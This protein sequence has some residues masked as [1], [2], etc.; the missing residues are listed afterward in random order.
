MVIESTQ[1]D[2]PEQMH[3]FDW[4]HPED[5]IAFDLNET[6]T[7]VPELGKAVRTFVDAGSSGCRCA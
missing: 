6:R 7:I 4:R 2:S 1:G 5:N 3:L